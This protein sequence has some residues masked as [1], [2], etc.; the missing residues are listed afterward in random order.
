[1]SEKE[2][3]P[4]L[5]LFCG[6]RK[7]CQPQLGVDLGGGRVR[8]LL[9]VSRLAAE[10]QLGPQAWSLVGWGVTADMTRVVDGWLRRGRW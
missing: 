5:R 4:M 7:T 10:N 1:M 6:G 3:L 9:M 2:L 8:V